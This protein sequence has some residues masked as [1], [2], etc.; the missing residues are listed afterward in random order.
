[1]RSAKLH[2]RGR[3]ARHADLVK[4]TSKKCG[5]S[6]SKRNFPSN[7][8]SRRHADHILFGDETLG[9]AIGKFLEELLRIGGVLGIA[10]ERHDPELHVTNSRQGVAEGFPRSALVTEL[11]PQR[12]VRRGRLVL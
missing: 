11:V 12:R 2:I 4:C 5:K 1:M 6:R 7:G 8:K 9:K 3:N 10:V